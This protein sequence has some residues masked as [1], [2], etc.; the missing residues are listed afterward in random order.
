MALQT[1]ST[2]GWNGTYKSWR[3]ES[4][5]RFPGYQP[6][7]LTA[8]LRQGKKYSGRNSNPQRLLRRQVIYP[9]NRPEYEQGLPGSNRRLRFWRPLCFRLHQAPLNIPDRAH[10]LQWSSVLRRPKR[11]GDRTCTAGT[12][13]RYGHPF[14]HGDKALPKRFELLYD[15]LEGCCSYPL[16]YGNMM[17]PQAAFSVF[18]TIIISFM[19]TPNRMLKARRLSTEGSASPRNHLYTFDL[20]QIPR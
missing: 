2:A 8:V 1:I 3:E 16:S 13:I 20:S 7:A 4:N 15:S 10:E 11:S 14:H 9:V 6:G 19:V 5:L 12:G 17:R 18:S